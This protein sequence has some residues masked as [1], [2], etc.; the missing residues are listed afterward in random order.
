MTHVIAR[1]SV[2]TANRVTLTKT[3][4]IYAL[5]TAKKT[6]ATVKVYV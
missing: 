2:M 4:R 6:S 5:E 1:V 3:A